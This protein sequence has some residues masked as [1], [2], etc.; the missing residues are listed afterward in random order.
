MSYIAVFSSYQKHMPPEQ[1]RTPSKFFS[2]QAASQEAV[3]FWI[4]LAQILAKN[5]GNF[6]TKF[7]ISFSPQIIIIIS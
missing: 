2:L 5:I 7:D 3:A 1:S 6:T 4:P